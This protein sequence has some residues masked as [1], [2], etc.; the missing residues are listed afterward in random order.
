MAT[1]YEGESY[2]VMV[3]LH[4]R[5]SHDALAR[6]RRERPNQPLVLCLTGTDLY[7]DLQTSPQARE[8]LEMA[9]R[10]VVLQP[11]AVEELEPHLHAKVRVI[12]QSI[13]MPW[14]DG[15]TPGGGVARNNRTGRRAGVE[16]FDVVVIG[17]LREVKDPFRAALAARLLP[18]SSRIRVTQI[19]GEL[20]DGFADQAR[21]EM[22]ANPRYRWV[23]E[24]PRWRVF[25]MLAQSQ[26]MVLSSRLEGGAN[27]LSE[28][29]V[30]HVPAL[31]SRIA[32]SIGLLGEDYPGYFDV[33]DTEALCQLL[34]RAEIDSAFLAD[35][36]DRCARQ[37][38]L[39]APAAESGAWASLLAELRP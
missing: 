26:L 33:G 34:S 31:A 7:Q 5:R 10:I 21:A 13:A 17:H 23:G 20:E 35:L 6:Y 32:G 39:F 37:A 28:A 38:P 18:G 27:V 8:S 14:L 15:A 30:A 2:D 29:I 16:R 9:D 36:R 12:Y 19:G 11:K 1:G 25:R 3:A 24:T 4:A 22:A